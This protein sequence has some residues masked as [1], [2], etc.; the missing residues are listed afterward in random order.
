MRLATSGL[1][2]VMF[3]LIFS[4]DAQAAT[5]D[6]IDVSQHQPGLVQLQATVTWGC[7]EAL[8][9]TVVQQTGQ[10]INLSTPSINLGCVP[11]GGPGSSSPSVMHATVDVA[12]DT[13]GVYFVTWTFPNFGVGRVL[14]TQFIVRG[15]QLQVYRPVP[16]GG[17]AMTAVLAMM[18]ILATGM[19]NGATG[20]ADR[21][22]S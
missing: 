8:L 19:A 17:G 7:G 14:T 10:T 18:V 4:R 12:Y 9:G 1:L 5:S 6:R 16:I 13:D 3:L 15:G 20:V 11:P 21:R 22:T 2:W